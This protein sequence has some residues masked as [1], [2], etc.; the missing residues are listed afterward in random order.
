MRKRLS[1]AASTA[2]SISRSRLSRARGSTLTFL[3]RLRFSRRPPRTARP[4]RPT[5][6]PRSSRAA[7][8]AGQRAKRSNSSAC[9]GGGLSGGLPRRG[10]A[11][12][13]RS[14]RGEEPSAAADD[15]LRA[16]AADAGEARAELTGKTQTWTAETIRQL[17]A[18]LKSGG[19]Y[20]GPIDG[21][22]GGGIGP[23]LT[24]WRLLGGS[25]PRL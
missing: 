12:R 11:T 4:A 2:R 7:S 20:T 15:L 19:Y 1:A 24:Q 5:T 8:A 17:Q 18:R 22:S 3:A 25:P 16:V 10:R 23:A 9:C 14:R 6:S 21:K 13:R